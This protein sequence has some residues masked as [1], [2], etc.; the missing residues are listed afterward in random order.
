MSLPSSAAPA[1]V[2]GPAPVASS[3]ARRAPDTP[4]TPSWLRR[5][6]WLVATLGSFVPIAIGLLAPELAYALLAVA[7]VLLVVG[8]VLLL[9][10]GVADDPSLH[11]R[12]ID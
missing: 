5:E 12:P 3:V 7:G 6:A 10:R 8:L 4:A 9:R 2:I 11:R 1:P